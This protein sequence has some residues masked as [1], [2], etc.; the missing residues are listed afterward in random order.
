MNWVTMALL[1]S[2]LSIF[3][4]LTATATTVT[5]GDI[6]SETNVTVPLMINNAEDVA[7]AT[8]KVSYDP[9]VIVVTDVGNSDFESFTP[10]IWY[11][12]EGWVKMSGYN[13]VEGISG[14]VIFAELTIAPRGSYGEFSELT[15]EVET[16]S[17]SVGVPID[18]EV[19][20]GSF[21]I[22]SEEPTPFD[23]DSPENPYPSIFGVHNGT[24][25]PNKTITVSR[26]YT[27]PCAG[28]GGHSEHIIIWNNSGWN[29][30]ASWDGYKR[31]WHNITFNKTFVLYKNETYNYT[32]RTGSYP[33]IHHNRTLIVLNGEITCTKFTDANGKVYY[34]W[35]PAIRLGV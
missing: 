17:D 30:T 26:L 8:I 29:R 23:T 3:A 6:F 34:D 25:K 31:D 18:T 24:I 5:I 11:A 14:D 4:L 2:L 9:S 13:T 16:L 1:F 28:T 15:I 12:N 33:Q 20:N 22:L 27:Y 19:K 21:T 10:N 7:A 32:I 35:I